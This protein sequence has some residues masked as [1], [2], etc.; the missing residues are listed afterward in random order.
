M[1]IFKTNSGTIMEFLKNRRK[2]F[3]ITI[4]LQIFTYL[5]TLGLSL[6]LDNVIY[7]GCSFLIY[8]IIGRIMLNRLNNLYY[9]EK[10]EDYTGEYDFKL[11]LLFPFDIIMILINIVTL[12]VLGVI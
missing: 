11:D 3:I 1:L 9:N 5:I 7:F 8:C 4:L 12:K 6:T 10:H 2:I